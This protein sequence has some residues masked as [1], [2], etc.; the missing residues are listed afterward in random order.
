MMVE[1]TVNC[2]IQTKR[3]TREERGVVR[4][5]EKYLN[6]PFIDCLFPTGSVST[7]VAMYKQATQLRILVVSGRLC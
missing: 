1:V 3:K 7:S 6:V 4:A 5:I 2:A